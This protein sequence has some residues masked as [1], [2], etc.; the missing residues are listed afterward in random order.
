M[1]GSVTFSPAVAGRRARCYNAMVAQ[2]A[3]GDATLVGIRR[4]CALVSLPITADS[5]ARSSILPPS[6]A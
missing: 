5:S 6:D 3:S 2:R 4:R 1:P